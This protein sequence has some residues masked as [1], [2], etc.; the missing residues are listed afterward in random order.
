MMSRRSIVTAC[1]AVLMGPV[2]AGST[3]AWGDATRKTHLTF[4]GPVSLTGVTLAAGTYTFERPSPDVPSGSS[5][6]QATLRCTKPSA[7]APR[8]AYPAW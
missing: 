3:Q 5:P 8:T 1:A 7:S 2:I 6:D 4:S